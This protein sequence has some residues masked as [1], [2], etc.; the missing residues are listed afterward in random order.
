MSAETELEMVTRHVRDGRD[1][2]ADQVERVIEA[3]PG[4]RDPASAE[5]LLQ[6][7]LDVQQ[8]HVDHL[9]R[10][11]SSFTKRLR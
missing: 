8:M 7:F 6:L 3:S 1:L 9:A 2:A 4:R 10:L 11:T 5:S